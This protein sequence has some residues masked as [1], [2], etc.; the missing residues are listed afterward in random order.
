M[1]LLGP[2]DFPLAQVGNLIMSPSRRDPVLVCDSVPI[3]RQ[4]TRVLN[5]QAKSEARLFH[6]DD[7]LKLQ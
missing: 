6:A 4:V 1:S 7:W 3:A 2:D 5:T